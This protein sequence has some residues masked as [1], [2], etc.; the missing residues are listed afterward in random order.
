[1]LFTISLILGTLIAISSYSWMGMWLGLEINLLSI[2]PLMNN[3]KIYVS[4]ESSLKYFITQALASTILLY[5]IIMMSQMNYLNNLFMTSMMMI[6]NCSMFTK[7]GAAPFHFWFPEIMDG[8]TWMISFIILTWQKIAPMIITM[9]NISSI[10]LLLIII[11]TSMIIGSIMGLNQTSMRKILA[12]SS[13]NHIGWMIMSFLMQFMLWLFYFMIYS[14][15]SLILILMMNHEKIFYLNQMMT[16][17]K[18]NNLLKFSLN[19][20]FMSLGGLPPF[21]GFIPKW[22]TLNLMLKNN[23]I[24]MSLIMVLITLIT[25]YYYIRII[26]SSLMMNNFQMLMF[27]NFKQK[28][29]IYL[30]INWMNLMMLIILIMLINLT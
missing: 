7:M 3:M 10:K 21:L 22:L 27:L 26:L 24:L 4:S 2:I 17:M 1:M 23:L 15:I 19:M 29:W 5:T 8:L 6:M 16:M 9:M 20:N 25:L 11:I 13:I 28:L 12:Y 14:L 18:M 30:M